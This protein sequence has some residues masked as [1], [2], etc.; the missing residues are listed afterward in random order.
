[1]KK[2]LVA[3][4][5]VFVIAVPA[6]IY[7][8]QY[9]ILEGKDIKTLLATRLEAMLGRKVSVG[10]VKA[11][12]LGLEALDI[13]VGGNTS[14]GQYDQVAASSLTLAPDYIALFSKKVII[15]KVTMVNPAIEIHKGADGSFDFADILANRRKGPPSAEGTGFSL[16]VE[17]I[18]IVNAKITF[19]DEA[20][21]SLIPPAPGTGVPGS[22][23]EKAQFKAVLSALTLTGSMSPEGRLTLKGAGVLDGMAEAIDFELQEVLSTPKGTRI[24]GTA[25]LRKLSVNAPMAYVRRA[26]PASLDKGTADINLFFDIDPTADRR[27]FKVALEGQDWTVTHKSLPFPIEGLGISAEADEKTVTVNRLAFSLAGLP[28]KAEGS[29]GLGPKGGFE[30]KA[31]IPRTDARALVKALSA[32]QAGSWLALLPS[33]ASAA[34][35]HKD[36]AGFIS[37]EIAARGLFSDPMG[38]LSLV[39][40]FEIDG[41]RTTYK[42]IT[43][44]PGSLKGTLAEGLVKITGIKV[45]LPGASV[46]GSIDLPPPAMLGTTSTAAAGKTRAPES[47]WAVDLA[48]DSPEPGKLASALAAIS[49]NASMAQAAGKLPGRLGAKLKWTGNPK[50]AAAALSKGS[51]PSGARFQAT[52]DNLTGA[53]IVSLLPP[54][55]I[56]KFS[57]VPSG[58]ASAEVSLDTASAA[59]S[60]KGTIVLE[61]LGF[62]SGTIAVPV[63]ADGSIVISSDSFAAKDLT[64]TMGN[65]P[66]KLALT[67]KAPKSQTGGI[68]LLDPEAM[69]A[70]NL[71]ISFAGTSFEMADLSRAGILPPTFAPSGNM[72]LSA[73]KLSGGASGLSGG[74]DISMKEGRFDLF[75]KLPDGTISK[76]PFTVPVKNFTAPLRLGKKGLTIEK[77]E[78]DVCSSTGRPNVELLTFSL[79]ILNPPGAIGFGLRWKDLEVHRLMGANPWFSHVLKGAAEGG[80]TLSGSLDEGIS[81]IGGN[82]M[83]TATGGEWEMKGPINESLKGLSQ[84]PIPTD[85]VLGKLGGIDGIISKTQSIVS[86][87]DKARYTKVTTAEPIL[88]DKGKVTMK[89]ISFF[90]PG[91]DFSALGS[92]DLTG[93]ETAFDF[94]V[95]FGGL[96]IA[97]VDSGIKKY[98][99]GLPKESRT[100]PMKV[101]IHGTPLKPSAGWDSNSLK[102]FFG[103]LGKAALKA[104]VTGRLFGKFGSAGG[105][106]DSKAEGGT[107]LPQGSLED[108]AKAKAT[109][110]LKDKL[111]GKLPGGLMDILTGGK[112][113][114]EAAQQPPAQPQTAPQQP[115]PAQNPFGTS[116]APQQTQTAQPAAPQGQTTEKPATLQD[117]F[118]QEEQKLKDKLKKKFKFF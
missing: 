98:A 4:L 16:S 67:G 108:S 10:E 20:P 8:L 74:V 23:E 6:G 18:S 70:M 75:S 32:S 38:T 89:N 55:T 34:L 31:S 87:L 97:S 99:E 94:S 40:V 90:T 61:S 72:V 118:K 104:E 96:D 69:K 30:V 49:G 11:G 112:S 9:S 29:L 83:M 50:V 41:L 92:L 19:Q 93:T 44:G 21:D 102:T 66:I 71:D 80:I 27:A 45:S 115:D 86:L 116:A 85:G 28:V 105:T 110:V 73:G 2:F 36:L 22:A 43:V 54:D 46:A 82:G 24:R 39:P 51:I 109:E 113:S 101:R 14:Y 77:A 76:V 107:V 95:D 63:K 52:L 56:K 37:L 1:M 26:F 57:P 42:G 81:S 60:L 91:G 64:I 100:M 58:K 53:A 78:A 59:P 114:G 106:A 33:D 111:G 5:I 7:Y 35:R 48:L 12:L 65:S 84:I 13:R 79:D 47:N 15:R 68:P 3:V 103:N 62:T 117:M 88:V 17:A 25:S